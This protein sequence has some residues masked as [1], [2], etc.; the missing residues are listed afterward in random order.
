MLGLA[1]LVPLG[2]LTVLPPAP[3][4][5]PEPSTTVAA[6]RD[7]PGQQDPDTPGQDD[8]VGQTDLLGGGPGP[9]APGA[10]AA[11]TPTPGPPPS[12]VPGPPAGDGVL[13]RVA[14]VPPADG[15][16]VSYAVELEGGLPLDGAEVAAEVERVLGDPR[17]WGGHEDRPAMVRV[18]QGPADLRV[19]VTSPATTD[20]LC[21]PLRT[22]GRLSCRTGST[23]VLNADRWLTGADAYGPDLTGYRTY[24][25]NHEVGHLL[26]EGHQP[27]PAAGAPAPVMMQQT[28]GVGACLAQP[29]PYP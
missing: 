5:P 13:V 27:C 20:R 3:A 2:L 17:S 9:A 25:V 21:A 26:G 6:V 23:A 29:W 4:G 10:G 14:G 7:T 8:P 18:G 1:V 12:P 19:V 16:M 22:L 28:K 24:L 11:V 15:P